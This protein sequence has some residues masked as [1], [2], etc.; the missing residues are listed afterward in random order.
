MIVKG[1]GGLEFILTV[2]TAIDASILYLLEMGC[3]LFLEMDTQAMDDTVPFGVGM[4]LTALK[5]AG[6]GG[7]GNLLCE[8]VGMF[9]T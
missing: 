8:L 2:E 5:G 7:R 1:G 3:N 4:K 9:V 6:E